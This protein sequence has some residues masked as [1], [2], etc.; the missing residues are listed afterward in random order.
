[1]ANLTVISDQIVSTSIIPVVMIPA[2]TLLSMIFTNR[3][4]VILSFLT[5]SQEDLLDLKYNFL[6]HKRSKDSEIEAFFYQQ[7]GLWNQQSYIAHSKRAHLL[8]WG[9]VFE[10]CAVFV[11]ASAAICILLSFYVS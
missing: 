6:K 3:L 5:P 8:R 7:D 2:C 4:M 9:I 1:M 10:Y 11:F